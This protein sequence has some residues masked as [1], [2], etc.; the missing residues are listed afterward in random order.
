MAND[1]KTLFIAGGALVVGL[2]LG[3][4]ASRD[5]EKSPDQIAAAIKESSGTVGS[6]SEG[7]GALQGEVAALTERL[8][9]VEAMVG[10]NATGISQNASG[11]VAATDL[12]AGAMAADSA[13]TGE[14]I[15]AVGDKVD[16]IVEAMHKR[17]AAMA[18]RHK[19]IHGTA[20]AAATDGGAADAA[21]APAAAGGDAAPAGAGAGQTVALADG[22]I[23]VFVSSVD[24]ETGAVRVAVNGFAMAET[25]SFG[26]PIAVDVDG[27][28][29]A[30]KLEGIDRGHALFSA[31][32]EE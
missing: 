6:L 23:R 32:C 3:S 1:Q 11:I 20:A 13:A 16:S 15:A 22:A 2:L 31:E 7:V 28:A 25:S 26:R 14:A 24:D 29:C 5:D 10:Q 19:M 27:K 12:L 8:A 18:E 21:D 30:V 4:G 9:A 17:A